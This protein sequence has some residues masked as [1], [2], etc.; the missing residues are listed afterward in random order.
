[1]CKSIGRAVVVLIAVAGAVPGRALTDARW[2]KPVGEAG[3]L[4]A[5]R[6][7]IMRATLELLLGSMEFGLLFT[8]S[9]GW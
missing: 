5:E 4:F 1:M 7:D 9:N 6:C 2:P 3:C 8:I